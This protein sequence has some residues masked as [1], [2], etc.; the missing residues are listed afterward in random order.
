M[1]MKVLLDDSTDITNMFKLIGLYRL[2][3]IDVVG[4]I[5]IAHLLIFWN[6]F[7][8]SFMMEVPII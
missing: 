1:V 5:I 2:E 6:P 8:N 4:K 3:T 7:F